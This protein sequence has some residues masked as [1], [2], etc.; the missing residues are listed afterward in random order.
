MC[1]VNIVLLLFF[2]YCT[3]EEI[4]RRVPSFW[5]HCQS[6]F[7]WILSWLCATHSFHVAFGAT[8][9]SVFFYFFYFFNTLSLFID[10]FLWPT[11]V[12]IICSVI[13]LVQKSRVNSCMKAAP[14]R[15]GAPPNRNIW[16]DRFHSTTISMLRQDPPPLE[17]IL[18]IF[19]RRALIFFCLKALGKIWKMTPLLCACA[20]VITLE[21]QKCRKR[22]P[23]SVEFNFFINCDRQK[24]FSQNERRRVDLQNVA[25][26]FLIFARDLVM[27]F[28]SLATI[29]PPFS[30]F[31]RP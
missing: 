29:L 28:Q 19:G 20:A 31:E 1:S 17:A 10:S 7:G 13:L 23:R 15:A 22:A 21:T 4:C 6:Y 27:V 18:V 2:Y 11:M 8:S 14:W 25:S 16:S 24:R 5:S 26:E 12:W 30:D 9:Y 3:L